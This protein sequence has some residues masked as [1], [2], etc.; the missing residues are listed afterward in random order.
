MAQ[1]FPEGH[2]PCFV[3]YPGDNEKDEQ[4]RNL[5]IWEHGTWDMLGIFSL[6]DT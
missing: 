2:N 6:W 1:M 4:N 5:G 3:W